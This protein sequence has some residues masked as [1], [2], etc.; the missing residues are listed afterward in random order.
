MSPYPYLTDK[1]ALD[2]I[3]D[4]PD[5]SDSNAGDPGSV[6]GPGRSPG[7]GNGNPFQYSSLENSMDRG[8]WRLQPQVARPWV[9]IRRS[10]I[11]HAQRAV[12]LVITIDL[13][14]SWNL[15]LRVLKD[16]LR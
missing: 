6:P 16:V 13:T 7:E 5:G 1:S 4:F 15:G 14:L 2:W 9:Q 12:Y 8:A 11:V 3:L 10:M